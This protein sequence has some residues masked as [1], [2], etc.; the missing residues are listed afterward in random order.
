MSYFQDIAQYLTSK[1]NLIVSSLNGKADVGHG[2]TKADVGLG[3][4]DNTSDANKP[5]SAA[6]QTALNSKSD[7]GHQHE[8]SDVDGLGQ[9]LAG[10]SDTGHSHS[11][12]DVTNLQ[13]SL[14]NKANAGHA[15]S[16]GELTG[17]L[18][19]RIYIGTGSGSQNVQNGAYVQFPDLGH[20]ANAQVTSTGFQI[21]EAGLYL[22]SFNITLQTTLSNRSVYRAQ[23]YLDQVLVDGTGG[24]NY[25][26]DVNFGDSSSIYYSGIHYVEDG[27]LE[28]FVDKHWGGSAATFTVQGECSFSITRIG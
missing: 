20:N 24:R 5:I 15:H 7:D 6:Q 27:L 12:S 28:V 21:Q 8:I 16:L 11:I 19:A 26:R 13:S 22:I 23:L 4:V 14:N 25:M 17:R 1:L 2:H 10:K 18:D 3:N 9:T